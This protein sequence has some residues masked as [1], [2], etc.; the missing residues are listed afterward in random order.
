MK[1]LKTKDVKSP[2]R[3][4]SKSAGIDF[5]VPNGHATVIPPNGDV[6]IPSG[7]RAKVPVG[8]A[9]IAFNK[10]GIATKKK[11]TV[12]ACVV[13]EDY[14]GEIH[15]HLFN[16]TDKLIIINEGE[17]LIQFILV[18]VIYDEPSEFFSEHDVFPKV[19]ER[20]EGGFGSTNKT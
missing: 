14:Q 4:T 9:L 5:F 15:I 16:M 6:I 17:K 13:D 2:A 3:G 18:P 20:G 7:I 8:F 12:G 10:S 19:S 11:L 1:Y